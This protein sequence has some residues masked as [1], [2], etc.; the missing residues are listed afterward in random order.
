MVS[1][2]PPSAP[3][4]IYGDIDA[5]LG[6]PSAKYTVDIDG[7][8][9]EYEWQVTGGS[10]L[11]PAGGSGAARTGQG[12]N[13]IYVNW[14]GVP[15]GTYEIR[16]RG[17][18][19]VGSSPWT[20]RNV[21]LAVCGFTA[22]PNP[23]CISDSVTFTPSVT[24]TITS[25]NWTFGAGAIP[26]SSTLKN[27][28][29]VK[30]S[31]SGS[32]SV[33]L[34]AT[35]NTG[36]T[37]TYTNEL[38]VGQTIAGTL[39]ASKTTANAGESIILSIAGQTGYVTKWQFSTNGGTNW[40]DVTSADLPYTTPALSQNISYR[41]V[42]QSPGCDALTTNAVAITV[43]N[44]VTPGK[45]NPAAASVCAGAG[46]TTLTLEGLQAGATIQAWE[47]ATEPFAIWNAISGVTG[48]THTASNITKTTQY[49][50]RVS[51]S[52][53]TYYSEPATITIGASSTKGV[54]SGPAQVCTGTASVNLIVNTSPVVK[55]QQSVNGTSGWTDI[56]NST[57][58]TL[59][60]TNPTTT[61]FYK[62]ITG[63]GT[64]GTVESDP[65][66]VEIISAT[67]NAGTI[68]PPASVCSG[69]GTTLNIS[70]NTG[71]IIRWERS[72]DGNSWTAI[73]N[74]TSATLATGNLTV[75][76]QYRVV[77][78]GGT[79]GNLTSPVVTVN[80]STPPAG[81]T[82]SPASKII[83][84]DTDGGTLTLSS[85]TAPVIKWQ[86]QVSP[87][88]TWS[89][90]AGTNTTLATGILSVP[91]KFRAV[92]KEGTCPEVYSSEAFIDVVPN[93]GG[94]VSGSTTV[95]A[96]NNNTV[97]TLTGH[98]GSVS[99]WVY[100]EEPYNVENDIPNSAGLTNYTAQNMNI[101]TRYW[102]VIQ[103]VDNTLNSQPATITVNEISVGGSI[104]GATAV[105][106]GA[107]TNLQLN[108]YKGTITKWE[109]STDAG[110]TWTEIV[111][112]ANK[113]E[114][115]TPAITTETQFMVTVQSGICSVATSTIHIISIVG[116]AGELTADKNIVCPGVN[117]VI[118]TLENPVG[119][120]V[121]WLQ[122]DSP[123]GTYTVISGA[124]GVSH[125][126]SNLSQNTS[127][128][129]KVE[130]SAGVTEFTNIISL[131]V[132]QQAVAGTITPNNQQ[133]CPGSSPQL[134]TLNNATGELIQWFTS[135]DNI[136]FS[137]REIPELLTSREI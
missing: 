72:T 35:T 56:A 27:P 28:L 11:P 126:V 82:V 130:V 111:S 128:K 79:C 102:A 43:N 106:S 88:T 78:N 96:G 55:W 97:L 64:C 48:T 52:G 1:E 54:I 81:G 129:V 16:V 83:N 112:G 113:T 71:A 50:V 41:A 118:L 108:G 122:S 32:K 30:Y 58:A 100:S 98:V 75:A 23:L 61:M 24:G 33:R 12:T 26:T 53:K 69:T 18:N 60:I 99:K 84:A 76:T 116:N 4:E 104:S 73:T 9:C 87:Y 77:S 127:Y 123:T 115:T 47:L 80:I 132:L 6:N 66:E 74:S 117:T 31:S 59:T 34:V 57:N 17:K 93:S 134:L 124:S 20:I 19:N 62:V 119:T 42:V 44:S 94:T 2:Q 39:S 137:I 8:V 133:V 90:V 136:T 89:D 21:N 120:V 114:I 86:K 13:L 10:I 46:S 109:F 3:A 103:G 101:T 70:G 92:V 22:N 37:L 49:R 91:T 15:T 25:W 85:T 14:S 65:Y 51:I 45:L 68:A 135:N 125:V 121:E 107:T 67:G 5:C 110:I 105:S 63:G 29:K 7:S 38:L 40:T 95:C 131:Q 36:T